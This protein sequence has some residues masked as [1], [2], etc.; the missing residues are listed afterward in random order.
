[1][2]LL[3]L[4]LVT[5]ALAAAAI[6]ISASPAQAVSDS[7]VVGSAGTVVFHPFT[8]PPNTG[9][10]RWTDGTYNCDPVNLVFANRSPGQVRDMLRA[11]GWT[12][13]DLGSSQSLHFATE[14]R[15][16]QD[17]HVF[18]ADGRNS[19]GESLR[20][21]VRLWRVRGIASTVTV[22]AA[23]HERRVGFSDIID[24]AWEDAEAAVATSLCPSGG[25]FTAASLP[26]QSAMQGGDGE[27]RRWANNAVASILP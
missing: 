13:F 26:T 21:H 12:T 7:V 22:G 16:S 3:R 10:I 24:R 6:A 2:R 14:T 18:R 17:V 9:C 5:P 15:Y 19:A 11:R 20:Y 1:M 8:I 25:C 27:W 4:A 23:H